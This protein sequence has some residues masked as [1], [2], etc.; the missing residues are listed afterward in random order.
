[1]TSLAQILGLGLDLS[2]GL[3]LGLG[4]G[5]ECLCGEVLDLDLAQILAVA[6][7]HSVKTHRLHVKG[8]ELL[9]YEALRY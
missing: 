2:L 8:I 1:M 7:R 5:L 6:A 3:G 4:S 9:V